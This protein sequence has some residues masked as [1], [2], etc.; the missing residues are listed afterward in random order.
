MSEPTVNIYLVDQETKRKLLFKVNP[1]MIGKAENTT[2]IFPDGLE[3]KLVQA[4]PSDLFKTNQFFDNHQELLAKA[5]ESFPDFGYPEKPVPTKEDQMV[6]LESVIAEY[7]KGAD[8]DE[9]MFAIYDASD[10]N[11][12]MFIEVAYQKFGQWITTNRSLEY[13]KKM[14]RERWTD[15]CYPIDY[16][17]RHVAGYMVITDA[18]KDTDQKMSFI[19]AIQI[20]SQIYSDMH[21]DYRRAGGKSLLME[22]IRYYEPVQIMHRPII[23]RIV[24]LHQNGTN[25]MLNETIPADGEKVAITEGFWKM[26]SDAMNQGLE[27]ARQTQAAIKAM[28][29]DNK[30][31]VNEENFNKV[32]VTQACDILSA[33]IDKYLEYN[34]EMQLIGTNASDKD[35]QA[36]GKD[37]H[38]NG[39]GKLIKD[40]SDLELK[41]VLYFNGEDEEFIEKTPVIETLFAV[42]SGLPMVIQQN[43]NPSVTFSTTYETCKALKDDL[44]QYAVDKDIS[45]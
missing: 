40:V 7:F 2:I 13:A 11:K 31:I 1:L 45:K 16:A 35:A 5:A 24:E 8:K 38:E 43:Q 41:L 42:A 23:E 19:G 22:P 21:T 9:A 27:K 3:Y 4:E 12:K 20:L 15:P 10:D 28:R 18:L 26:F 37:M 39:L 17:E 32:F 34:K 6:V 25:V 29:D 14:Q 30:A 44:T 33:Y 36:L